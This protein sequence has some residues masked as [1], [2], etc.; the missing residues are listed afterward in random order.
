MAFELAPTP[1]P[2][3]HISPPDHTSSKNFVGF[4]GEALFLLVVAYTKSERTA[5]IALILAVG[6]SG[7]AISGRIYDRAKVFWQDDSFYP[8]PV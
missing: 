1:V 4:G 6:C 3:D 7:F 5:I 8:K 2:S